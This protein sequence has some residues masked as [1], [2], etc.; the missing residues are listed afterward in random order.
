[1]LVFAASDHVQAADE[2]LHIQQ[3]YDGLCGQG[4]WCRLN[5][6]RSYFL[7]VNANPPGTPVDVDANAEVTWPAMA[8]YDEPYPVSSTQGTTAGIMEMADRAHAGYWAANLEGLLTAS[9]AP[10]A[11]GDHGLP[12]LWVAPN[13][14]DAR[15]VISWES[16]WG[17]PVRLRLIPVDG[18]ELRTLVIDG[19][20]AGAISMERLTGGLALARGSYRL[21]AQATGR[22]FA[23]PVVI[24]GR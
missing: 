18:R 7:A 8:L 14:V 17:G 20:R 5:P 3:A 4:I 15:S 23:L 12:M 16:G 11:P 13:P 19:A 24:S 1:M 22:R 10:R 2:H 9:A 6:D 21:E